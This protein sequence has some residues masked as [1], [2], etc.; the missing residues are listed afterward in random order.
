MNNTI[1]PINFNGSWQILGKKVVPKYLTSEGAKIVIHP[2]VYHPN[3]GESPAEIKAAM[4]KLR[5]G[6][7][8]SIW[9]LHPNGGQRNAGAI[10]ELYAPKL[11]NVVSGKEAEALTNNKIMLDIANVNIDEA[12]FTR[13]H[14]TDAFRIFDVIK[15]EAKRA[16]ELIEKYID[17]AE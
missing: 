2:T 3:I 5:S 15:L 7:F 10:Y 13:N 8:Y 16:A 1:S 14:N 12:T 17:K 4:D 6:W 11:G 9:R